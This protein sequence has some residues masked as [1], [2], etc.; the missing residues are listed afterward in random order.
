M[1]KILTLVIGIMTLCLVGNAQGINF[2]KNSL[3]EILKIA[4]SE[5]KLVFIDFYTT[6]CGPCKSLD[7]GTFKDKEV[8]AFYNK[9]FINLKL[10]A[11]AEG[12]NAAKKYNVKAF[13]TLVFINYEEKVISLQEGGASA[14]DFIE[15]GKLALKSTNDPD[16]YI[17]LK[18]RYNENKNDEKFLLKYIDAQFKNNEPIYADVDNYLKNQK[19]F[20]QNGVDIFEF[21]LNY[22]KGFALGGEAEIIL[23]KYY[24]DF[25]A[26][27]TRSEEHSF[28]RIKN[29][30]LYNTRILAIT[31]NSIELYEVFLN[32]WKSLP[33]DKRKG[34]ELE[35][36]LELLKIRND[37]KAYKKM[38]YDYITTQFLTKTED[39]IR[40]ADKKNHERVKESQKSNGGMSS[41]GMIKRSENAI[42][43]NHVSI[44]T[45]ISH[46]YLS[47]SKKKK[48]YKTILNW[49][50]YG[51]KILPTSVAVRDLHALTLYK[52]GKKK[53]ALA[54]RKE[55]LASLEPN[56]RDIRSLKSAIKNWEKEI[57]K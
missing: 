37:D 11:E 13:P 20:K 22:Y 18:K 43:V 30:M 47:M 14:K 51:E 2:R 36:E 10:D 32:K 27:A 41:Y 17:N 8:G 50:S 5:N 31:E 12:I 55:I 33:S 35:L 7:A 15:L 23:E 6:W 44:I 39:E 21:F 16:S 40:L 4:K 26:R 34:V 28:V 24:D 3:N 42:A 52:M 29:S 48:D 53:E 25:F 49:T 45:K 19:S 1:K 46:V 9:N 57:N 38:A 56:N 54:K